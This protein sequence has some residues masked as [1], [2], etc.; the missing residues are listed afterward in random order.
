CAVSLTPPGSF[1]WL[2]HQRSPRIMTSETSTAAMI[3]LRRPIAPP[4]NERESYSP[5]SRAQ[6][7]SD[8]PKDRTMSFFD[9]LDELRARVIRALMAFMAGFIACYFVSEP[10]MAFLRRPL[11]AAMPEAQRKL[12]FTSLFEN[13]MTHLKIS[14]YAS[15]FLL[16]PY[17][18]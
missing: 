12:Y 7:N 14:G 10:I 2:C 15:A 1:F 3:E 13:F 6:L 5:A 8:G 9:H 16:S 17:L 4:L 11:F 18:F